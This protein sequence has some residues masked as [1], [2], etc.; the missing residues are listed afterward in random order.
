MLLF[1][2]KFVLYKIIAVK[3]P[4]SDI[5]LFSVGTYAVVLQ[6]L[7]SNIDYIQQQP[8]LFVQLIDC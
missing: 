1:Y 8:A 4:F 3:F 2:R 6:I 5:L 7:Y